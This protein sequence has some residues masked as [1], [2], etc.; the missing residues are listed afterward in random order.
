MVAVACALTVF[1]G[2][3][4]GQ[5]SSSAVNGTV[6]DQQG[7]VIP[8]TDVVLTSVETG[9]ERQAQ[10]NAVGR[11]GFVNVPPGYYTLEAA[12]EGFRTSSVE[13]FSLVVNQTATFD[14]VLE[15]GA[16]TDSVTVE[17]VGAQVQSSSAELGTAMTEQ[18]VIDLPLNGRNFTQLL[19][20]TP[21][22]SPVN[23]AQSRGGFGSTSVGTFSFPSINGQNN[24]SN[25]FLT[26]GVNNQGTMTSTYAVPPIIDSIQE[27]K[28]QSH[29]DLAEFGSV[30]G[31]VVNVV[32]KSGQNAVHG[33]AWWFLRN[34]NL[35]ARNTF[36]RDKA[37]LAQNM[38][39]GTVGGPVVTNKTFYFGAFQG[40]TNRTPSNRN[41]QVPTDANLGG[42]LSNSTRQIYDPYS[43]RMGP[44]GSAVRDPF[45][46]NRIPASRLDQGFLHYI[47]QT[48]PKPIDLGTDLGIFNQRDTTGTALD[49]YEY[50]GRVDHHFSQSDSAYVRVSGQVNDRI[51]SAGRQ[52]LTSFVNIE[53]LNIAANWVHTFDE[54]MLYFDAPKQSHSSAPQIRSQDFFKFL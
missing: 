8:G 46:G 37:A 30:T 52:G 13:P 23:V 22:A 24:R 3:G 21:G 28:V 34:D 27:F 33:S 35:D 42:D 44:D 26:D 51:G 40:F 45:Q 12:V 39:G 1:A 47:Q 25:L 6:T 7:A 18:Q 49:Q 50:S 36:L 11:Y 2:L 5:A 9:I 17:A 48:V 41:Y 54:T 32:T 38:F 31:G 10:T 15:V 53:N 14:I 20:L 19:M 16:V 4:F 29:N 43:T